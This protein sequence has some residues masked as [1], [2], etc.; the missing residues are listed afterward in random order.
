MGTEKGTAWQG[1][2]GKEFQSHELDGTGYLDHIVGLC[3]GM[4]DYLAMI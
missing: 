1:S 3:S 4:V 2:I